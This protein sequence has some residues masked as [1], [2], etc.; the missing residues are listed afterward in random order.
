MKLDREFLRT[1]KRE[2]KLTETPPQS[3]TQPVPQPPVQEVLP[4]KPT[5]TEPVAPEGSLRSKFKFE[6]D[7]HLLC[8][9]QV[10]TRNQ[11]YE[12]AES[13]CASAG[14]QITQ[15]LAEAMERRA[16]GEK[17]LSPREA[18][19]ATRGR[20]GITSEFLW[21]SL[22][23]GYFQEGEVN[24]KM[25]PWE[26]RTRYNNGLHWKKTA[27]ANASDDKKLRGDAMLR[28]ITEKLEAFNLPLYPWEKENGIDRDLCKPEFLTWE[29]YEQLRSGLRLGTEEHQTEYLTGSQQ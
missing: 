14:I 25:N 18:D 7:P 27:R 24:F 8:P 13:Y 15:H 19:I 29:R 22:K 2:E 1:G 16:A 4:E 20:I 26:L 17:V 23:N 10:A 11:A 12:F 5:Q 9:T 28:E 6:Y 3:Q 21:S